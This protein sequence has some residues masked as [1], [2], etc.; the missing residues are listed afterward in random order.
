MLGNLLW[1]YLLG[2]AHD[3][4]DVTGHGTCV[5]SKIIG[6][7]FGVAKNAD[8]VLVKLDGNLHVS[9]VI[10]AWGVVAAD[11]DSGNRMGKA[12]VINPVGGEQSR[13]FKYRQSRTRN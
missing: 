8:L 11:I 4:D 1:L 13:S 9:R 3:E 5:A 2:E 10:A 6:P 7:T 12:V